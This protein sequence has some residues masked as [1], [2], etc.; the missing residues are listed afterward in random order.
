M[1]AN[2]WAAA[3]SAQMVAQQTR[4]FE[5]SAAADRDFRN[6]R[7]PKPDEPEDATPADEPA[8]GKG[9]GRKPD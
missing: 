9:D 2:T 7:Q 6:G 3:I 1:D 8:G 4:F 5:E